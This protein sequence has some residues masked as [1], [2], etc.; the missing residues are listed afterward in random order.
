MRTILCLQYFRAADRERQREIDHCLSGNLHHPA[1]AEAVVWLEP[2]APPPPRGNVPVEFRP[3]A[4]RLRF[5][6]WLR[7]ARERPEAIVVLANADILLERG[8]E[9][10]ERLLH[11]P[12][13]VLALTPQE[14][15]GAPGEARLAGH[16]QWRQDCWAIRGDAPIEADLEVAAQLPLGRPG[17]DNRLAHALWCHGLQ[18]CN[19]LLHLRALHHQR[20]RAGP[21][22]RHPD[23]LFGA[24]AHVHP[25]LAPGEASELEQRLWSRQPERSGGLQIQVEPRSGEGA[26]QALGT[27]GEAP[28]APGEPSPFHDWLALSAHAPE[29]SP[30]PA[31]ELAVA[32][33]TAAADS[34][35]PAPPRWAEGLFLPL[36]TLRGAGSRI[37]LL[38][39]RRLL[40]LALRLPRALPPELRLE[41]RLGLAEGEPGGAER[42][43]ERSW[44]GPI[45][46]GRVQGQLLLPGPWPSEPVAW[47]HLR[48][49]GADEP[50][51]A[52]ALAEAFAELRL[53]VENQPTTSEST[54]LRRW[55]HRFELRSDAEGLVAV[56]RF[57][58]TPRRL[59][60]LR[61]ENAADWFTQAFVPPLLEWKADGIPERPAHPGS[62]LHWQGA[63]VEAAARY[64]HR[65]WVS[66][67]GGDEEAQTFL[68]LPWSGCLDGG[69]RAERL[70]E[71]Y[72]SRIRAMAAVLAEAGRSLR[73]HT[74]CQARHW[75]SLDELWCRLGVSDVWLSDPGFDPREGGGELAGLR[76]HLW[77]A[78]AGEEAAQPADASPADWSDRP[79]LAGFRG[80]RET[81]E[82]LTGL[83]GSSDVRLEIL[84]ADDAPPSAGAEAALFA[85]CRFAL[86][87]GGPTAEPGRFW[88]A[89]AA[90][91]L[92]V[93]LGARP[94]LPAPAWLLPDQPGLWDE[95]APC[96][97][98]ADGE[99][100]LK[101]LR[102]IEPLD[103][104]AR[105]WLGARALRAARLRTC[106]EARQ[107]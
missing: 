99:G 54:P 52:S 26:L 25:S 102:A 88:R 78:L 18:L 53:L 60:G 40:G 36:A 12:E 75:Q 45:R 57:W 90:G 107:G 104:R 81:L 98:G 29:A 70:L 32:P 11:A 74:V 105:Q 66:G 10:L 85:H 15:D 31:W 49:L 37:S 2:G 28:F 56:D 13:V 47:L 87:P 62:P 1:L 20:H 65:R 95:L 24:C 101:R 68:S 82:A 16:P 92:P 80:G 14:P 71:A 106:F 97:E 21:Y 67:A 44:Q 23:R 86:L 3:L 61:G 35:H 96:W 94:P 58:P 69:E 34:S 59:A 27:L 84:A 33:P 55:R 46:R 79:L 76:L 8:F 100:L 4:R 42:P 38:R 73:V 93:F 89:L 17:A 19:P 91:A 7:L 48:L 64:R 6:D 30:L 72:G 50:A 43:G 5:S 22:D 51:A 63:A 77:P 103:G 83:A 9:R 39:A 41:L